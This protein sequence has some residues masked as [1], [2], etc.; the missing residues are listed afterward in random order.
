MGGGSP[1]K[2]SGCIGQYWLPNPSEAL[3]LLLSSPP[4]P[5]CIART[6]VT[7]SV[8]PP[9]YLALTGANLS[10]PGQPQEQT[11]VGDPNAKVE[12]KPQLK[13]RCSVA[14]ENTQN[15][16]TNCISSILNPQG[17]LSKLCVNKYIKGHLEPPEKKTH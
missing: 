11:P 8:P 17:Q 3:Y 7:Q 15:L 6:P 12:I 1:G 2:N 9:T 16:P 5:L 13:P 4:T 10:P 14:K